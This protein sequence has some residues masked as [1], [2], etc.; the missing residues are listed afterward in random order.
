MFIVTTLPFF[1]IQFIYITKYMTSVIYMDKVRLLAQ[2]IDG[3][4]NNS[5]SA[6]QYF[7][8]HSG[9]F[10]PGTY[11]LLELEVKYI[12]LNNDY[13]FSCSI[14][15][16]LFF[17][18]LIIWICRLNKN[19]KIGI[20][21]LVFNFIYCLLSSIIVFSLYSWEIMWFSYGSIIF[22]SNLGFI[23]SAALLHKSFKS[24]THFLPYLIASF[25]IGFATAFLFGSGYSY[26]FLIAELGILAYYA[27]HYFISKDKRA[28]FYVGCATLYFGLLLFLV[29]GLLTGSGSGSGIGSTNLFELIK[30]YIY[31]LGSLIISSEMTNIPTYLHYLAGS[32]VLILSLLAIFIYFYKRYFFKNTFILFLFLFSEMTFASITISRLSFGTK[33]GGA[34]RYYATYMFLTL[35]ITDIF[36]M[37]A[38][39]NVSRLK[40]LTSAIAL[41]LTG[42]YTAIIAFPQIYFVPQEYKLGGYRNLISQQMIYDSLFFEERDDEYLNTLYQANPNDVRECFSLLREYSLYTYSL[43]SPYTSSITDSMI[44][45][46]FIYGLYDVENGASR[47]TA[48]EAVF[49]LKFNEDSDYTI[50]MYNPEAF[51]YNAYTTYLDG[52]IVSNNVT[53]APG[54]M[55]YET[56]HCRKGINKIKIILKHDTC[57]ADIGTSGDIRRLG[58][59]LS[60]IN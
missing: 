33:S 35:F 43:N 27:I 57:P 14:P 10:S 47:F 54:E 8:I 4:M 6:K 36:L 46:G 45:T 2:S 59:I 39:D 52:D 55:R 16:L 20:K 30:M 21:D 29:I 3:I 50:G 22:L 51:G 31:S 25:I 42:V 12:D 53:I 34:S 1:I 49:F 60:E 24:E 28:Y 9:H 32:F 18:L 17:T 44:T 5:L 11:M 26:A 56:F 15:F 40:K 23:L 58:V 37:F 41:M 7:D 38:Y 13:L 48:K 19:D